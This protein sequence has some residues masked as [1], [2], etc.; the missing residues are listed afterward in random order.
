MPIRNRIRPTAVLV[1]LLIALPAHADLAAIVAAT[2]DPIE[3]GPWL[4]GD[5]DPIAP[6]L[7]GL[8]FPSDVY[9][10]DDPKTPS[11]KRVQFGKTTLPK[12]NKGTQIDPAAWADSDG[13]ALIWVFST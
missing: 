10:V 4:D 1:T 3:T 8:P 5:C 12:L 6:A 9:L 7:C 11:G 2:V 13:R